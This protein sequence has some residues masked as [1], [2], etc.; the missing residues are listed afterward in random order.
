M[1]SKRFDNLVQVT[2]I[3]KF[4]EQIDTLFTDIEMEFFWRDREV[5][6][7]EWGVSFNN[8]R[9]QEELLYLLKVVLMRL[10]SE[11]YSL[12]QSIKNSSLLDYVLTQ[13]YLST[14]HEVKIEAD[15]NGGETTTIVFEDGTEK[16]IKD[17]ILENNG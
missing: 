15:M 2:G 4:V 6:L 7:E 5:F 17:I 12:S 16:T 8:E 13:E 1:E 14:G 3:N 10:V 9:Q 11:G